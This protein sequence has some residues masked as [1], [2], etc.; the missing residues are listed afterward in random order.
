MSVYEFN[1]AE[2]DSFTRMLCLEVILSP[3]LRKREKE[4]EH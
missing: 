1:M 2:A 4:V 3:E